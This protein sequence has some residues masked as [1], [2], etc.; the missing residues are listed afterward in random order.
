MRDFCYQL[1]RLSRKGAIG[2]LYLSKTPGVR[3][4]LTG[5]ELRLLDN[6]A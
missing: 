1:E 3:L 5:E 2:P 6:Q 4:P